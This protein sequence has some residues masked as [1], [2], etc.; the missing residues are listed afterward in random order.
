MS[1]LVDPLADREPDLGQVHGQRREVLDGGDGER[2][3]KERIARLC[4]DSD[5]S[6]G[7][8]DANSPDL[9]TDEGRTRRLVSDRDQPRVVGRGE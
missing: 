9:V 4:R 3:A 2:E 6:F 1:T 5:G 7:A 8:T